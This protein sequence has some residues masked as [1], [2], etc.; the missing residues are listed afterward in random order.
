MIP[1]NRSDRIGGLVQ[2]VLSDILQKKIKDPRLKMITITGVKISPDLKIAR[3][4]FVASGGK[5]R[6]DEA[7]AG[8]QSA[9]GYIKRTLASRISLRYMPEL[10][11]YYDKSFDYGSKIDRLLNSVIKNYGSDHTQIKKQ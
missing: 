9:I 10:K 3:I 11:F 4:Y 6:T 1:Y 5:K 7:V 2:K 8:F